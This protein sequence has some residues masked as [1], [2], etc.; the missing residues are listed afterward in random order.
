MPRFVLEPS[1]EQAHAAGYNS[2]D[3]SPPEPSLAEAV[4]F[5]VLVEPMWAVPQ[6]DC[7]Q[8]PPGGQEG[9][10]AQGQVQGLALVLEQGLSLWWG[11]EQ[12]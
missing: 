9:G 6:W 1:K 2:Y 12:V 10:R 11:L 7:W 4:E 3:H 5:Q 8:E